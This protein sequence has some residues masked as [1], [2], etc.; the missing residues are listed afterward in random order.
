MT[1]IVYAIK[2]LTAAGGLIAAFAIVG[3]IAFLA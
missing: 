2:V 3:G 1:N